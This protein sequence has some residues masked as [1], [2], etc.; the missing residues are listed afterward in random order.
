MVKKNPNPCQE[1]NRKGRL[2]RGVLADRGAVTRGAL[3][4][5]LYALVSLRFNGLR[6]GE[7]PVNVQFGAQCT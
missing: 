4:E 6:R 3:G 2:H 5:G 7:L 1:Q